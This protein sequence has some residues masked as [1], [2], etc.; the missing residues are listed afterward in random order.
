MFVRV[1]WLCLIDSA[2]LLALARVRVHVV[3]SVAREQ[4]GADHGCGV[5]TQPRVNVGGI[6]AFFFL[7]V[8][9]RV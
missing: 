6:G 1:H 3:V 4:Q 8:S 2:C 9:V 5:D 7:V